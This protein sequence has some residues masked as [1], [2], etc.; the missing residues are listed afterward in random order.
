MDGPVGSAGAD[1]DALRWWPLRL[2]ELTG[3][4]CFDTLTDTSLGDFV[5]ADVVGVCCSGWRTGRFGEG[6]SST[7]ANS[8]DSHGHT[9]SSVDRSTLLFWCATTGVRRPL[10]D[11][12]H[13]H[14][15]K[16][17]PLADGW[18][19]TLHDKLAPSGN[20]TGFGD[21][22]Q[23]HTASSGGRLPVGMGTGDDSFDLSS[24]GFS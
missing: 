13:G 10:A 2:L 24:I 5:D 9:A 11:V 23:G 19:S 18:L 1:A 21:A 3:D 8:C 14:T 22:S 17:A 15:S 7:D 20:C 12:S 16:S 6:D 4:G